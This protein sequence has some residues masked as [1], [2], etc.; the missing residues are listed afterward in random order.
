MKTALLIDGNAIMHRAYHALPPFKTKE[1]IPT[2]ALY[3]FLTILKK[4]VTDFQPHYLIVCFDTP[5]PTFRKKLYKEYQSHRPKMEDDLSCQFSAVK[6]ALDKA[7]II[8]V[9]KAGFEADDVIGT[10]TKKLGKQGERV[11]IL[12]GD[13]DIMQLV[14]KNTFVVTPQIG[15][16]QTKIYDPA[17]VKEKL[18]IEPEKIPDLKALM[19]DSSDNYKGAKG[20][21][22]K[23]AAK[24]LNEYHSVKSVLANLDK[25]DGK[26]QQLLQDYKDNILLAHQ[27]ATIKTDVDI[28]IKLDKTVFN[29]FNDGLKEVLQKYQM[30]SLIKRFFEDKQTAKP[31]KKESKKS[32]KDQM[33]LF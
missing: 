14:N 24:L 17:A 26:P 20:I 2:N 6:E 32:D 3:G 29:G 23:T 13:R 15:F 33:G 7:G 21:G 28:D 8:H 5:V 10:I 18:G 4:A 30:S 1:G 12:T 19:G 27:L 31:E 9:E 11:L 22:P 16:A 25:I